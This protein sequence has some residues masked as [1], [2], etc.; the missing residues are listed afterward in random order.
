VFAKI[1]VTKPELFTVA[2]AI[3]LELHEPPVV[4]LDNV[5][6]RPTQNEADPVM[7]AGKGFT[8]ITM[9][10]KQPVDNV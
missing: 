5:V 7:A 6:V 2:M 4:I 8:V 1:P 10:V 9:L 3:L